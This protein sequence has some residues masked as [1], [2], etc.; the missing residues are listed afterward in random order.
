MCFEESATHAE[1]WA[2]QI[3][4]NSRASAL[5]ENDRGETVTKPEVAFENPV[6]RLS[7][8]ARVLVASAAPLKRS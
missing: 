1:A 7:K 2:Q 6:A 8:L 3:R 4:A 5:A